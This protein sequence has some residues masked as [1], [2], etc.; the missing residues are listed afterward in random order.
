[1]IPGYPSAADDLRAQLRLA[2]PDYIVPAAIVVLDAL[3]LTP[4]GKVDYAA[5]PP[6]E[7]GAERTADGIVAPTNALE[8]ALVRLW[9]ELLEIPQIGTRDHFFGVGGDSLLAVRMLNAV[10][11]TY[12]IDVELATFFADAT[13]E[14]LAEALRTSPETEGVTTRR[15][16]LRRR[17][18]RA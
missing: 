2:L 3:P 11:R 14:G 7:L 6:A 16:A 5:L 10:S 18:L 13:I 1:M 4:N 9:Q 12:G 8:R 15:R 17:A